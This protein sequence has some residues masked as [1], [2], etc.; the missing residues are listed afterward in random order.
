MPDV[1]TK[2]QVA[3]MRAG[4]ERVWGAGCS[5][6]DLYA[7]HEVL[8]AEVERLTVLV[9]AAQQ[10]SGAAIEEVQRTTGEASIFAGDEA[11]QRHIRNAL[12]DAVGRVVATVVSPIKAERDAALGRLKHKEQVHYAALM[13]EKSALAAVRE[14]R[15]V[16]EDGTKSYG[17]IYRDDPD[18]WERVS[19]ALVS[20]AHLTDEK[21][22]GDA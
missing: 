7:S 1:L 10:F 22:A 2:E 9:V 6:M 4:T 18:W 20:T 16:L 21:G 19:S 5:G 13:R 17:G 11:R 15:S 8:R 3:E 14:L 12:A